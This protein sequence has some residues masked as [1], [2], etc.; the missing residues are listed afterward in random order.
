MSME[1]SKSIMADLESWCREVILIL[2]LVLLIINFHCLSLLLESFCLRC[3]DFNE[4]NQKNVSVFFFT[5]RKFVRLR[6][7]FVRKLIVLNKRWE[8]G[9][10]R[11]GCRRRLR[12]KDDIALHVWWRLRVSEIIGMGKGMC[13]HY[14]FYYYYY[15]YWNFSFLLLDWY[16]HL[17]NLNLF[18]WFSSGNLSHLL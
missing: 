7:C 5:F 1:W 8:R 2:M 14:C 16:I 12:W 18:Y 11:A 6:F 9:H 3:S 17:F 15:Y 13:I 10:S 4:Y